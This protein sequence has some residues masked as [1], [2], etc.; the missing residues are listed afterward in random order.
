MPLKIYI[1][2]IGC[3]LNQFESRAIAENLLLKGYEISNNID[4]S[5]YVIVNTCSV[6]NN[7]D[8]KSRQVMR[9]A[10]IKGKKV[11][12]TGCYATTGFD[13]L[14]TAEYADIVVKNDS[15]FNI[16]DL[17][18]LR[19][20]FDK[21]HPENII[22][23]HN[24]NSN[25][26]RAERS[27]PVVK[28]FERTRAF[29][30]IQDGCDK[31]CSY[32]KIPAARGRSR[33]VEPQAALEFI[34]NLVKSGYKEIVLTGVNISDYNYSGVMLYD[35][36]KDAILIPGD[37]RIRLSSLQPDEF[38][39]KLI[40]LA[41]KG[42]AAAKLTPHFHL[43]V[44]SGS[45]S[46]L[47]RM[48]RNYSSKYFLELTKIIRERIPDCGIT[49]DIITGFPEETEEEFLETIDLVKKAFFTRV[50]IFSYSQR[51][52]TKAALMKDID[53][54]IKKERYR[55]LEEA[56]VES[57]MEFVK[58]IILCKKYRVLIETREEGFWTGYT[59]NYLK[60]YTKKECRENEF[61]EVK[62]GNAR[63]RKGAVEL[64]ED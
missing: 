12:A 21:N 38:D 26:D 8:V 13:E 22:C 18:E 39:I 52:H 4:N 3:K 40:D 17:I 43:S 53:G 49:T 10:K 34:R 30:K 28:E 55:R 59:P 1:E 42:S 50:H 27:F 36:L 33:S 23:D 54:N 51:S 60:I 20:E 14:N 41:G 58:R 56:A 57:G 6:T 35:L 5:D 15:K 2:T 37:F 45:D 47:K 64:T 24:I 11:I 46:V 31:F 19:P 62:A 16:A 63:V 61:F 48:N 44:Q 25:N 32:C 7:A 29:V 9:K